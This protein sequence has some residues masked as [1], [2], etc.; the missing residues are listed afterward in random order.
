MPECAKCH[1]RIDP[2]GFALE[3][4]DPIG[5]QRPDAVD[6]RTKLADGTRLEG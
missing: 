6:T 3:Q 2:Y 5:R 1:E 4:F